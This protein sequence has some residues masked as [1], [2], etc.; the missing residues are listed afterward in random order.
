MPFGDAFDFIFHSRPSVGGGAR[1]GGSEL[2][3]LFTK[4]VQVTAESLIIAC[5]VAIP[6]AL[7]LGHRNRG[8]IT[9]S[10]VANTGRA[11]PSFALVVFFSSYFGLSTGN[12]V[13]AMVILAVPPI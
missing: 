6:I 2:W 9:A 5:A 1:I 4:H 11:I 8:Q 3:P 7:W 12:L 13:F 10:I